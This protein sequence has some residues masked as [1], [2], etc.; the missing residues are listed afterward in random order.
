MASD[1]LLEITDDNFEKEVIA[2]ELPVVV[3][4]WATW[5]APCLAIG[6]ILEE[7]AGEYQGRIKVGK[8]DV[9]HNRKVAMK[10]MVRSIP[11][12]L[13]V[14]GGRVVGQ[15]IGSGGKAAFKKL[16]DKGL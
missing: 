3:D 10:Y 13:V 15:Q 11:T 6:P 1:N 7:L 16:F 14:K 5:C 2:S 12:V 8:V 4:F 9:D